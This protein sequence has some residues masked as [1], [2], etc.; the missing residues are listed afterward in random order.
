MRV[1]FD[2]METPLGQMLLLTDEQGALRA[3]DWHDHAD[4][5]KRLLHRYYGPTAD[6]V[7][8]A[9][10]LLIRQALAAYFSGD[11]PAINGVPVA[12]AGTGFQQ[13]VWHALRQIPAGQTL[14]YKTLAGRLGRPA[15]VRAVGAANGANP[16]GLVVP[17]H[18][19]VGADGALT[20]Y[21]GGLHRKEWLLRHEG[22]SQ[23]RFF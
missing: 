4:R 17:C 8:G 6:W 22:G 15:A 13:Q 2:Q 12:L 3:L 1:F 23:P 11:I 18:R 9:A 10:P 5:M 14:S 21:G 19:V 16:V 7:S 20:G